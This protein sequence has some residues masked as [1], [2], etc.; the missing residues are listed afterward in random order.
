MK[1]MQ[2]IA[3][4]LMAAPRWVSAVDARGIAHK[5]ERERNSRVRCLFCEAADGPYTLVHEADASW[6]PA[7]AA[8]T[9]DP[10]FFDG[11]SCEKARLR[12]WRSV[13]GCLSAVR[14]PQV[15]CDKLCV[16]CFCQAV[17]MP[18]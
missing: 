2:F 12:A 4:A 10:V 13:L 9:L 15:V 6:L 17:L 11:V 7:M 14:F 16:R 3:A 1:V 5:R 8:G 18:Y